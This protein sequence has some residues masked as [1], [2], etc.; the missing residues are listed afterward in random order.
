MST[1]AILLWLLIK[2]WFLCWHCYI[3]ASKTNS[4]CLSHKTSTIPTA[5]QTILGSNKG[6]NVI[7]SA[8]KWSIFIQLWYNSGVEFWGV[9]INMLQSLELEIQTH[10]VSRERGKLIFCSE[11]KVLDVW[12]TFSDVASIVCLKLLISVTFAVCSG[13]YSLILNKQLY[14]GYPGWQI[15]RSSFGR[16]SC[17]GNADREVEWRWQAL[18]M[19]LSSPWE[20][21]KEGAATERH[22]L[23]CPWLHCPY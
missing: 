21:P 6:K 1:A 17:Q 10:W 8:T 12:K 19:S 20:W 2:Y 9:T 4:S 23:H 14:E 15:L 13:N 22:I 11:F 3:R 16:W 7:S 18:G 5:I